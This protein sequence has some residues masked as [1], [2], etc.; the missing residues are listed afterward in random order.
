MET[1]HPGGTVPAHHSYRKTEGGWSFGTHPGLT[2]ALTA[3]L[4][5][6]VLRNKAVFAYT[7]ED[8]VGYSGLYGDFT[9]DLNEPDPSRLT[10]VFEKER[11]MS[12]QQT[13]AIQLHCEPLVKA[14]FIERIPRGPATLYA[15]NCVCAK[16]KNPETGLHTDT[17]VAQDLR[18]LNDRTNKLCYTGPRIEALFQSLGKSACFTKLDARSGF[19]QIH[20]RACDQPKTAFWMNHELWMF[21]RLNFGLKNGPAVFQTIMDTE[22]NAANLGHICCAYMDD[23]LIHSVKPADHA[24][25]VELVLQMLIKCGLRAHPDKS[26][27]GCDV[28]EYLGHNVSAVGLTPHESK[29]AA[30]L[31]IPD[32]T[33]IK[34]LQAALGYLGYYRCYV[35]DF[36]SKAFDLNSLL[37][38]NV[39][40]TWGV[41][42]H[43]ALQLLKH[44][45]AYNNRALRRPDYTRPFFLYSDWSKHGIGGVLT[46]AI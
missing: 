6:T 36:S 42:Q 46:R 45:L 23:I 40:W 16:K 11:V 31:A 26:T 5:A 29:I 32:P 39:P 1:F 28:I 3:D 38:Q 14:G 18:R 4:E 30:I 44:E 21:K 34:E 2:P 12:P 37:A 15:C 10:P 7:L 17:R 8:L 24:A 33:C 20:I 43:D 22:I 19:H 9:L 41:A 13:A 27:F 35:R 25:D